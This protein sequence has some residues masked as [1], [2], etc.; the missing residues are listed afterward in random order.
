M[1]LSSNKVVN[2]ELLRTSLFF[3]IIELIDLIKKYLGLKNSEKHCWLQQTVRYKQEL[4]RTVKPCYNELSGTS[5][6][7]C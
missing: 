6:L 3:Q 5:R 1:N 2:N 4:G 7:T